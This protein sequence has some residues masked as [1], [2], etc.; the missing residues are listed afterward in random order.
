MPYNLPVVMSNEEALV[1]EKVKMEEV[2]EG[3]G[4][5]REARTPWIWPPQSPQ[6]TALAVFTRV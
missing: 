4:R 6:E 2:K 5:M 1:F 3:E